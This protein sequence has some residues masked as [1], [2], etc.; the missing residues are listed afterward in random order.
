MHTLSCKHS[1][2]RECLQKY[3]EVQIEGS[4]FPLTCIDCK[5][6]ATEV[7]LELVLEPATLEKYHKFALYK[8]LNGMEGVFWC[9]TPECGYAVSVE[10]EVR[11]F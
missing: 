10:G 7:D 2:H 6:E 11:D 5:E 4:K 8:A 9:P 1:H 3:W